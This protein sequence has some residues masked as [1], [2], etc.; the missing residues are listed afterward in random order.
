MI[1]LTLASGAVD[2]TDEAVITVPA[3]EVWEITS[4]TFSQPSTGLAKKIRLGFG[5]TATA[6]NVK[7][8]IDMPAGEYAA[9]VF[10]PSWALVA[11]ATLN[12]S[13]SADDDVATYVVSGYKY[14]V[15]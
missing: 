15:S 14:K 2:T 1:P 11:A 10:Y 8:T 4:I 7:Y 12:L 6:I 9:P 13:A 5:T 3:G